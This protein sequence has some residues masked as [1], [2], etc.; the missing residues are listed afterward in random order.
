MTSQQTFAS[1]R[2]RNRYGPAAIVT[3]ASSGIGEQ[4]ARK[5]ASEGFD[6]LLVARRSQV[7]YQL[8]EELRRK[9]RISVQVLAG[10]LADAGSTDAV[11]QRARELDVGLLICSAGF[12]ASGAF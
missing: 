7:L 8:A 2:L 11:V 9:H 6:L 12:G 10:D 1:S 5:L 4:F 3:G